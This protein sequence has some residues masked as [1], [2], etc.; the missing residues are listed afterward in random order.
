MKKNNTS[1]EKVNLFFSAFLMIAYIICGYFFMSFAAAQQSELVKN[2]VMA[3]I[4]TVFGLLV[5]YATRVGE[6]KIVK[7]FSIVTLL[8]LDIP[9]LFIILAFIITGF[10]LHDVIASAGNGAM[11]FMAAIALGYG[12]PYT[13][14]SG[15]ETVTEDELN[16]VEEKAEETDEVLEGGVEADLKDAEA[17]AEQAEE[18]ESEEFDDEIVVE[19]EASE[20]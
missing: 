14:I 17:E 5:F 8:V 1:H 16:A 18:A 15:F 9:A 19:G 20:E 7:R 12:I 4:F 10:P 11:A 2:I 13:F 3:V 6:R